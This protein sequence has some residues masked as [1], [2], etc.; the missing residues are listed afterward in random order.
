MG[1]PNDQMIKAAKWYR[2]KLGWTVIPH[3]LTTE[4]RKPFV[5]W[6]QYKDKIVSDEEITSWWTKYP[7]AGM[8]L[9]VKDMVIID[10]DNQEAIEAF[11]DLIPDSMDIPCVQT[12]KGRHYY[13]K[14][15]T[16]QQNKGHKYFNVPMDLKAEGSLVTLPPSKRYGKTYEWIVKPE[17]IADFPLYNNININILYTHTKKTTPQTPQDTTLHHKLFQQGSRDEDLFHVANLLGVAR[18]SEDEISQVINILGKNCNPPLDEKEINEKI[19]S[20]LKRGEVRDHSLSQ[21]I[22]EWVRQQNATFNLQMC[23]RELHITTKNEKKNVGMVLKRMCDE[24]NNIIERT[25]TYAGTFRPVNRDLKKIDLS[26]RTDLKG[27][28]DVRFP[29]GVESWIRVFPKNVYIIAGETDSGKSAFLMN[30]AK[31]NIGKFNVRYFS[32]EMGKEEFLDRLDHL[33]PEAGFNPNFHFYERDDDFEQV[34]FPDDINIIDYLQLFENFYEMP[35]LINSIE[36]KLNNGIVF[37]ALQKPK[38]RDEGEGGERTKNLARLYLSLSPGKL[39]IVKAKN[40]RDPKANPNRLEITFKLINGCSFV[41][42]TSWRK[43]E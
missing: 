1:I 16:K 39:K 36:K 24:E 9:I 15:E 21:E 41:N 2:D 14:T 4:E 25:G 26:D 17:S 23:H 8:S 42:E 6:T 33:W 27:A 38:S 19:I 7:S 37:I 43:G 22:R 20:A 18:A 30:F 3:D 34:I 13:L 28:L 11:E 40:W 10:C 5:K 35:K 32:S 29:L 12:M 31:L